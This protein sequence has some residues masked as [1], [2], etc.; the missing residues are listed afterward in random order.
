LIVEDNEADEYLITSAIKASRLPA[1]LHVARDGEKAIG[2]FDDADRNE[3]SPCPS[4]VVLDINLP[5]K[6]GSEVLKHIR[7]SRRCGNIPV[8][9]VSTSNSVRDR[10]HMIGL[11]ANGY[12]NKPSDYGAFMLLGNM[13]RDLLIGQLPSAQ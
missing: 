8:I 12:F 11:G 13:V 4:L 10:E 5:R 1:I 2:F 7:A 3:S 6:P 9:V